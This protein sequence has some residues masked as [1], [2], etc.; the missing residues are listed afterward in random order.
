MPQIQLKKQAGYHHNSHA[1]V[2][3]MDMWRLHVFVFLHSE[4]QKEHTHIHT[5]KTNSTTMYADH[6]YPLE[7]SIHLAHFYLGSW[8]PLTV[9]WVATHL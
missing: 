1:T 6:T 9:L 2:A 4:R 3:L 8:S 5:H 7:Q